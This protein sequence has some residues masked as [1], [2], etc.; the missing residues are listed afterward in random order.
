MTVKGSLHPLG[1]SLKFDFNPTIPILTGYDNPCG[2][3]ADSAHY[4]TQYGWK[5]FT[6]YQGM[7]ADVSYLTPQGH[8]G[9]VIYT[10]KKQYSFGKYK[11]QFETG[12]YTS[13]ATWA[14]SQVSVYVLDMD[15][16]W[17]RVWTK[18]G[19]PNNWCQVLISPEIKISYN[20][21]AVKWQIDGM[22]GRHGSLADCQVFKYSIR[23]G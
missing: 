11:F 23:K 22:Y 7:Q 6:G 21:K 2:T 4:N 16:N 10:P 14:V 19:I 13:Y 15:G 20:F 18:G 17:Q 3:V 9:C 1:A 5:A 12:V 8:L